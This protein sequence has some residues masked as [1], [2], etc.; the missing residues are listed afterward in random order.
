MIHNSIYY[1]SGKE[2]IV[3]MKIKPKIAFHADHC[4]I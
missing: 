3:D 1:V 2:G 4:A